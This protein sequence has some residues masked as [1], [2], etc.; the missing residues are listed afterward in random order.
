MVEE[1]SEDKNSKK[2]KGL[3]YMSI[4]LAVIFIALVIVAMNSK[5]SETQNSINATAFY[6]E[7]GA[8][9]RSCAAITCD[10]IDQYYSYS[11]FNLSYDSSYKTIDDLPDWV[12]VSYENSSQATITGYI[13]KSLFS[14]NQ[15]AT[16]SGISSTNQGA[17]VQS[18]N[19]EPNQPT[20]PSDQT[21]TQQQPATQPKSK[22]LPSIIAEWSPSVALIA[23]SYSD[24]SADFGSGFLYKNDVGIAVF[25]NAHVFT[26]EATGNSAIS[27]SIEI[28]GDGNN[29]YTIINTNLTGG[30][31]EVG[32]NED[33]GFIQVANSDSYFNSVANKN[34]TICQQQEQTGD[35]VV[36]LGYPDYAGQFTNPTATQGIISGYASPYYTTS[37][38]IESGNSGGVA[39]DPDKDC[40]IGIPSAVKIGNYANLGRI[41]DAN[42][43]FNLPY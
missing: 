15:T 24:G 42:V 5:Y 37:A 20:Q 22:N 11:D 39:I 8:N 9:V 33:W 27:C 10:S 3:T 36:V 43:L 41:L 38:Q 17:Q 21:Q 30:P 16:N 29:Y 40:Y 4:T 12:K 18:S 6:I 35:S 23:C 32:N 28:P 1:A 19:S 34:L 7:N 14:L 2:G 26:E 13:S 25:T 31:F